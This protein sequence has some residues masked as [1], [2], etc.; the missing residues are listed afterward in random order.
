MK[1]LTYFDWNLLFLTLAM[2]LDMWI[3]DPPWIWRHIPHPVILFGKI[4]AWWDKNF[5]LEKYTDSQRKQ[6]G[7]ILALFLMVFAFILGQLIELIGFWAEILMVFVL[8]AGKSLYDHLMAILRPLRNDNLA[9]ARIHLAMIVGRNTEQMNESEIASAAIESCAENLSDGLIAPIFW[10]LLGGLPLMI[11]YKMVNTADS[12]IGHKNEKYLDFGFGAA[13]LDD[14]L[15]Y[16]PARITGWLI[17]FCSIK[18]PKDYQRVRLAVR[19]DG[20]LHD[21]PNA[22]IPEAAMAGALN[23]RLGGPRYYGFSYHPSP[24]IFAEGREVLTPKDLHKAIYILQKV[25]VVV[26]SCFLII[27]F[28]RLPFLLYP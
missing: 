27:L 20:R 24:W 3:G 8:L 19:R 23:I 15:N 7:L 13:K 12:M 18:L 6:Y 4:I 28:L 21:S 1:N 14:I 25:G 2:L 10:Y 17:L 16:I 5:N 9:K 22:G 11:A 26:V